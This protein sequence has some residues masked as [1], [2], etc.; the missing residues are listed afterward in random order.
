MTTCTSTAKGD[1]KPKPSSSVPSQSTG[2]GLLA[3]PKPTLA[4]AAGTRTPATRQ[5][6]YKEECS[7]S[8]ELKTTPQGFKLPGQS[9]P[10]EGVRREPIRKVHVQLCV[11]FCFTV[12]LFV[13]LFVCLSERKA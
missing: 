7:S 8:P 13:C 9:T 2:Q 5:D 1:D 10:T 6:L 3:Q 11:L 12:C 4:K